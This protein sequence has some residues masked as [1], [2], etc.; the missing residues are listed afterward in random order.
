M[1]RI[2]QTRSPHAIAVL[3]RQELLAHILKLLFESSARTMI[4]WQELQNSHESTNDPAIPTRPEH[5]LPVGLAF[6]KEAAV[7][8]KERLAFVVKVIAGARPLRDRVIEV[9]R[10]SSRGREPNPGGRRHE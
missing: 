7:A 5:L 3:Q 1:L 6:F 9:T 2:E 4:L 10:I 8:E